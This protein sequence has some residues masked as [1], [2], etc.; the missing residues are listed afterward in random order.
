MKPVAFYS[1]NWISGLT[2]LMLLSLFLSASAASVSANPP[3]VQTFYVPFPEEQVLQSLQSMIYLPIIIGLLPLP[4]ECPPPDGC[5][6]DGVHT[7][8]GIAVDES[9]DHLYITSQGNNRLVKVDASTVTTLG[10]VPTNEEPW[11]VAVDA[12]DRR[13]YVSNYASGDVWVYDADSLERLAQIP[14]GGNPGLMAILPE[15]DV[16]MVVVG[17]GSR[18]AVIQGTEL[19]QT[20]SA[21]GSGPYGIAADPV[22][23]QFF[24]SNRDTGHLVAYVQDGVT[25]GSRWVRVTGPVLNDGRT[26]FHMAY[27]PDNQKL[28]VVYGRPSGE[29]FVDVWKADVGNVWGL[30]FTI[31]V[32]NG[33]DLGSPLV[34]GSGI[35]VNR[36]TAN[37]FNVNTAAANMTVINGTTNGIR[38]VIAL[39]QDPFALAVDESRSIIYVGLR[40]SARLVKVMD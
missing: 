11:G 14:V 38:D 5:P 33:G 30:I 4:Q 13:V 2:V 21:I 7:L 9:R 27:N 19:V 39:G 6:V 1:R 15:L 28:Y 10:Q 20:L 34:G 17:E 18:V 26:L 36:T 29:W 31:P 37:L 12:A 3:P 22:G 32:G 8:K 23:N 16:V 24:I 35:G 40:S 25:D